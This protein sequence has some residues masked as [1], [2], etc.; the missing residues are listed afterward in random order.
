LQQRLAENRE[1][2][3]K[4]QAEQTRLEQTLACGTDGG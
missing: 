2:Q 3:Q 1:S 4:G